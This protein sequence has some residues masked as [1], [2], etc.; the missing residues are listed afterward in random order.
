MLSEADGQKLLRFEMAKWDFDLKLCVWKTFKVPSQC[1]LL[2]QQLGWNS[3][4]CCK[5]L[6]LWLFYTSILNYFAAK[7]LFDKIY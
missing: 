1:G 4:F 5:M 7:V 3:S 6:K 2:F